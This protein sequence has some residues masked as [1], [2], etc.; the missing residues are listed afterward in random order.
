LQPSST[1]ETVDVVAGGVYV[2][3]IVQAEDNRL[4]PGLLGIGG[5]PLRL[6]AQEG[7][8]AV[9]SPVTAEASSNRR[10]LVTAHARVV[11]DLNATGVVI[12]VRAGQLMSD[13]QAVADE[14]LSPSAEQFHGLL[15]ALLGRDQFVVRAL[16]NE[17]AVLAEIV[18]SSPEV[19][20]LRELTR[21]LPDDLG[22]AERFRLGELVARE[23]DVR[24]DRDGATVIEAVSPYVAAH[25]VRDG[26]D[27]HRLLEAAFLVD[28]DCR[29]GFEEAL[30]DVAE[31]MAERAEMQLF[32][33]MPPYD[34]VGG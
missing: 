17:P 12:P 28:E 15:D 19:A 16:Y 26:T 29:R 13:D 6:V 24:R 25:V 18:Q 3:G 2:Y 8:G 5:Q 30:E 20:R 22:H 7:V 27:M 14:L 23:L 4:P 9:V 21:D 11:D 1:S 32:G 31:A 33:P 10:E 34:F